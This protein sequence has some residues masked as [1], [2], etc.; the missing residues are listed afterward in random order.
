MQSQAGEDAERGRAETAASDGLLS[1]LEVIEQQPLAD[2][3]AS[4]AQLHEELSVRLEGADA[5]RHG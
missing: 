5:L 3:A 4:Y 2:R 1:T